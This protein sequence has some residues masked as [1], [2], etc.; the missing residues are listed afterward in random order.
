MP[1]GKEAIATLLRENDFEPTVIYPDRL[2]FI[3]DGNWK[4]FP[5]MQWLRKCITQIPLLKNLLNA[6]TATHKNNS[7]SETIV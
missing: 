5:D 6:V 2:S 7:S 1:K 3:C 4:T